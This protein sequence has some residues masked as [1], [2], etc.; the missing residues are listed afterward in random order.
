MYFYTSIF[1]S[2]SSSRNDRAIRQQ[3]CDR[4]NNQISLPT[5]S[6]SSSRHVSFNTV[7]NYFIC[8]EIS[9]SNEYNNILN[10]VIISTNHST[11]TLRPTR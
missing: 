4:D 1:P 10:F 3:E 9:K 6:Q 8:L 11:F 5:R 7:F 2:F